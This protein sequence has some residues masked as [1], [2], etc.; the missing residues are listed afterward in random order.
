MKCLDL[1]QSRLIFLFFGFVDDIRVIYSD[2]RLVCRNNHHVQIVYLFKFSGFCI[3]CPRHTCK[4]IIHSEIILKSNRG[5]GLVFVFYF[6]IF[7]SLKRLVQTLAVSTARHQTAGK[8]IDNYNST[9]LYNI[10]NIPF[11]KS[12]CFQRL[13][14][15]VE[16]FDIFRIKQVVHLQNIFSFCHPFLCQNSGTCFLVYSEILIQ[17][18]A[19]DNAVH[20]VVEVGRFFRR[21]GYNQRGPCFVDQYTVYLVNDAKI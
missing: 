17:F 8:F 10:I 19:R 7:F 16:K 15:V 5:E 20:M 18:K 2:H 12:M 9:V 4:F 1:I 11:E 6:Y 21:S 13:I 3:G 14:D